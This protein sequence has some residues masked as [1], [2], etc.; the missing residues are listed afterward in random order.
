MILV[1]YYTKCNKCG[2]VGQ[3]RYFAKADSYNIGGVPKKCS[4]CD[5]NMV[6]YKISKEFIPDDYS[7]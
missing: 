7:T 5:G 3:R 2:R 6:I 4:Q 1:Q